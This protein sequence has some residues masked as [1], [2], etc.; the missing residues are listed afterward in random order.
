[1]G[2]HTVTSAGLAVLLL[3]PSAL[4]S[5]PDVVTVQSEA[6]QIGWNK[7]KFRSVHRNDADESAIQ[8]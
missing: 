6:K 8:T 3:C 2:H 7:T 4:A 5:F 1:M